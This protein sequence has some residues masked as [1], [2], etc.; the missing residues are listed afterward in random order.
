MDF[1][2]RR[3]GTLKPLASD[4]AEYFQ[5][6]WKYGKPNYRAYVWTKPAEG[7]KKGVRYE[8][9]HITPNKNKDGIVLHGLPGG[10]KFSN[11]S[12]DEIGYFENK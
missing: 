12:V 2:D 11:D 7:Q 10:E 6:T 8:G 3:D 9:T 1:N 5:G 4:R